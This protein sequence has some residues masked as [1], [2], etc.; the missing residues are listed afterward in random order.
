MWT[1]GNCG[2]VGKRAIREETEM[3][4]ASGKVLRKAKGKCKKRRMKS[5]S[6]VAFAFAAELFLA[7]FATTAFA[8]YTINQLTDNNYD[9]L[10]PD[11]NSLGQAAWWR[12]NGGSQGIFLYSGGNTNQISAVGA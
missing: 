4:S 1:Y 5:V 8:D 9:D 2:K 7:S 12:N 11:F 6:W 3:I 10:G